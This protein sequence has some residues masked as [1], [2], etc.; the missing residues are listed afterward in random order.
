MKNHVFRKVVDTE[1]HTRFHLRGRSHLLL[2]GT[3]PVFQK[4]LK[5][6]N[7]YWSRNFHLNLWHV[8][9]S[10]SS[11][12]WDTFYRDHSFFELY[13]ELI[14][15][16][17]MVSLL[18]TV[19]FDRCF[20]CTCT[21]Y[22]ITATIIVYNVFVNTCLLHRKADTFFQIPRWEY[23]KMK[24]LIEVGTS[25]F[26]CC[27]FFW[28]SRNIKFYMTF[29]DN[30]RYLYGMQTVKFCFTFRKTMNFVFQ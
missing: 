26:W 11:G 14:S 24:S 7:Y 8:G 17:S 1:L 4:E 22:N 10:E 5:I 2:L 3:V 15:W 12:S 18:L 25:E 28:R 20:K 6:L 30:R 27:T 13:D 16:T 29:L 23:R 19:K 9:Y 21:L